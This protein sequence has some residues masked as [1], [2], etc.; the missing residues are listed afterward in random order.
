MYVVIC[1]NVAVD[2]RLRYPDLLGTDMYMLSWFELGNHML[3]FIIKRY[4]H[5]LKSIKQ[6]EKEYFTE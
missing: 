1:I 3:D 5:L 6:I 4:L 2:R